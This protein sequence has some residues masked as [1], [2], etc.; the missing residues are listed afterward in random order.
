MAV[1]YTWSTVGQQVQRVNHQHSR[2]KQDSAC[3]CVIWI[4]PQVGSL[5]MFSVK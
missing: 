2:H 4:L 1:E 5:K 3:A